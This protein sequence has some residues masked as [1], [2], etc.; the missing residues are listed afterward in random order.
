MA[1]PEGLIAVWRWGLPVCTAISLS[2][3]PQ[4][5][6]FACSVLIE[7][8]DILPCFVFFSIYIYDGQHF[9]AR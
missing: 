6:S 5:D 3:R 4:H 8:Q 9:I 1:G 7:R 2:A